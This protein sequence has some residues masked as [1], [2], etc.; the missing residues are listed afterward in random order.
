MQGVTY[1]MCDIFKTNEE[2]KDLFQDTTLSDQE[3][4]NDKVEHYR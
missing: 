3:E 4:A 1:F 2:R